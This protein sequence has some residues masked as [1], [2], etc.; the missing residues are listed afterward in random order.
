MANSLENFFDEQYRGTDNEASFAASKNVKKTKN[1]Q[2][3]GHLTVDVFRTEDDVVIKSTIAG[4][5][6]QD[7]DISITN[8]TVTIKG[9]RKPDE[10]IDFSDYDY[11]E[12]FWGPFSR[13]II[14]PEEI[15]PDNAKATLKNGLLILRLPKLSKTRIKKVKISS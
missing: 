6:D 12:L 9:T 15:D 3:E 13:T 8:D 1:K 11:R 7:L 2:E 5:T 4:I 10:D 14:L